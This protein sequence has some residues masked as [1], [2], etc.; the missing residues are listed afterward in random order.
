MRHTLHGTHGMVTLRPLEREDIEFVR[1]LRNQNKGRFLCSQEISEPA[2]QKWY[3][4]YLKEPG[5]C[6]FAV[7]FQERC[8]GAVA[9][10]QVDTDAKTA[11]F[12]RLMIDREAAGVGGLG[13]SATIAAC[14]IAHKQLGVNT[15]ALEV[16]EDNEA[17][18]ATYQRAGFHPVGTTCDD[19]GKKIIQ[20]EF[21]Q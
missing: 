20:M 17:A 18:K 2:Q 8:V 16:Y 6:M 3:D 12:G 5:D 1:V 10:Y 11:E 14:E 7:C 19:A 21:K 15:I 13:V 9:I 4:R